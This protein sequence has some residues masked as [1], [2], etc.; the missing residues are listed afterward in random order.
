MNVS[1]M[2]HLNALRRCVAFW[3][4]RITEPPGLK[5]SLQPPQ[6]MSCKLGVKLARPIA[7]EKCPHPCV[8]HSLMS[9]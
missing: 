9:L 1:G 8:A 3:Q 6:L 2:T 7:G 4:H 5:Q